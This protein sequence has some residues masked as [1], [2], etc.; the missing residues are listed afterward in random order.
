MKKIDL[1]FKA[2]TFMLWEKKYKYEHIDEDRT[3]FLKTILSLDPKKD[4]TS[5]LIEVFTNILKKQ[6]PDI[7]IIQEDV[8]WLFHYFNSVFL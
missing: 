2:D 4:N 5:I 6:N 7:E 3:Y 8:I 1:N